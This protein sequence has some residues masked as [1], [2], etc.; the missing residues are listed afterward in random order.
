MPKLSYLPMLLPNS[1]RHILVLLCPALCEQRRTP[2]SF[3]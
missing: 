1:A 3:A 2:R